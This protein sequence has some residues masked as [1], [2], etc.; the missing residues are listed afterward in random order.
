MCLCIHVMCA[1]LFFIV[2]LAQERPREIYDRPI[3]A[4]GLLVI[5]RV[6]SR[7]LFLGARGGHC[8]AVA[9]S[10]EPSFFFFLTMQALVIV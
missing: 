2:F 8:I 6:C 4:A 7:G 10:H 3:W 5:N 1:L 9:A